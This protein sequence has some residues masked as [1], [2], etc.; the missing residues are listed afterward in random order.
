MTTEAKWLAS[1]RP[2][3]PLHI[4]RYFPQYKM[5]APPTQLATLQELAAITQKYLTY[6]YIGIV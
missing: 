4:T 5:T 2:D 6:V 3:I 1:I